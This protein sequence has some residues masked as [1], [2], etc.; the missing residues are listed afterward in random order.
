MIEAETGPPVELHS[1][2]AVAGGGPRLGVIKDSEVALDLIRDAEVIVI[3]PEPGAAASAWN[4][5]FAGECGGD[6]CLQCFRDSASAH[7]DFVDEYLD[8][9]LELVQPGTIIRAVRTYTWGPDGFEPSLR[10]DDPETLNVLIHGLVAMSNEAELSAVEHGIPTVDAGAT[11][12]G[13]DYRDLAPEDYLQ[14]DRVHLA[15]EGSRVV[16]DLLDALGY[17]PTIAAAG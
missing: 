12:N 9:L 14:S 16:A 6:E 17:E 11:F 1:D 4:S 2:L 10:E 3:Q 7:R 15:D 8:L 13:P 5:Y